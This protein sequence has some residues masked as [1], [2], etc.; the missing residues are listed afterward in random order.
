[1]EVDILH[2]T[3]RN[4]TK[5]YELANFAKRDYT[6]R[7]RPVDFPYFEEFHRTAKLPIHFWL[8]EDVDNNKV[9]WGTKEENFEP[10]ETEDHANPPRM[11]YKLMFEEASKGSWIIA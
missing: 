1:M 3:V 11:I 4:V 8:I 2:K 7:F 5:A 6:F 10:F 9:W